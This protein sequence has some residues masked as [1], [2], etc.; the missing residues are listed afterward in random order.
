MLIDELL[1]GYDVI[2]R[3]QVVV[4]APAA[5]VYRSVRDLDVGRLPA[6][7]LLMVLRGIPHFLTGTL[8]PTRHLTVD[9]LLAFGFVVLADDPPRELVLGAVG[10]FWRPTSGM[11]T[12]T[13]TEFRDFSE[14]GFARAAWNFRIDPRPGGCVLAT[15]TRVQCIG[16]GARRWFRAYWTLIRPFSGLIRLEMLRLIRRDAE[17]AARPPG[18]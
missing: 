12:V 9:D 8:R 17:R 14:P 13:A 18:R 2:E 10:R 1:P 11:R 3:H 15:E 7:S 6:A 4:A 5:T 16:A